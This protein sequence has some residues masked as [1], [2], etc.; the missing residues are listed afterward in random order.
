MAP[1]YLIGDK[2][3]ILEVYLRDL[4]RGDNDRSGARFEEIA[5]PNE[6]WFE[7]SRW[8]WNRNWIGFDDP[9]VFVTASE[10]D[11]EVAPPIVHKIAT[12][13][14]VDNVRGQAP[15]W[16]K[17]HLRKASV[18]MRLMGVK[19]PLWTIEYHGSATMDSGAQGY[20]CE[21]FGQSVWNQAKSEFESF[22]WV[23]IGD[24]RGA[25]RFNNREKDL[26]PAPMGVA[27]SLWKRN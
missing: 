16:R 14:L 4:P 3:F 10:S 11:V 22:D 6:S 8:A 1:L 17:E 7:F 23:A 27:F 21:I 2:P 12:E 13:I 15:P 20:S 5:K 26:G 9:K 25:W 19:G 18:V 24:R